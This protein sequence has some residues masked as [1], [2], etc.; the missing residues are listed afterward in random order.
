MT[1]IGDDQNSH[2]GE[3]GARE[4]FG[5]LLFEPGCIV[6]MPTGVEVS[7]EKLTRGN[8][9]NVS[10]SILMPGERSIRTRDMGMKWISGP[11]ILQCTNCGW[12][13]R[14]KVAVCP[15]CHADLM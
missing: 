1:S 7:V 8:D 3:D 9:N 10:Y 6:K 2:P 12:E 11:F 4:L 5:R 13:A 15:E 14:E